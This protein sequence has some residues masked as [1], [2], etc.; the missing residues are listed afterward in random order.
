[1]CLSMAETASVSDCAPPLRILLFGIYELGFRALEA[2]T[3]R[4]LNVVGVVTKPDSLLEA[5]PLARLA[6][7][8]GRPLLA[9]ES[10]RD[11]A[12]LRQVRLLQPDLIAVAGY[13]RILPPSL[14]RLPSRGV[15]NLHASLLPRYRGPVPW[16]WAILN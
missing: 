16:K 11:A 2:L 7:E 4:R 5:Q 8:T 10:P 15:L 3:A 6:R 13:H 14:L 12:F 1:D 9:P